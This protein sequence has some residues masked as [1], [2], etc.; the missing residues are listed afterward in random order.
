MSAQNSK[1]TLETLLW[2]VLD[3]VSCMR[4]NVN[5]KK[6][7]KHRTEFSV[8]NNYYSLIV[9]L[10]TKLLFLITLNKYLYSWFVDISFT[11]IM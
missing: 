1:V 9:I 8:G 5:T 2:N 6:R 3:C 7:E 10:Q 11:K 4:V